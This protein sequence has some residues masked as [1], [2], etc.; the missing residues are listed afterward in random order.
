MFASRRRTRCDLL[1]VFP[2]TN[3]N[4]RSQSDGDEEKN[5]DENLKF[6]GKHRTALSF[7]F[8]LQNS[9]AI[10]KRKAIATNVPSLSFRFEI[11]ETEFCE[12]LV[13]RIYTGRE[14][15]DNLFRRRPDRRTASGEE[16]ESDIHRTCPS[17]SR[18][19]FA[20]DICSKRFVD[21]RL[22]SSDRNATKSR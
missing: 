4:E 20:E 7:D 5:D 8:L 10:S 3:G 9:G 13:D 17:S 11:T 22:R 1:S 19:A 18:S 15:F 14:R 12:L 6:D 2:P 21:V 16:N